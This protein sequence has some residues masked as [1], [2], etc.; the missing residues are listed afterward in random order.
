MN[1]YLEMEL[2]HGTI[3]LDILKEGFLLTFIFEDDFANIDETLQEIKG[4]IFRMP[5]EP[6]EWVQ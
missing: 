4:V 1:W 6:M 3:E 5:Q 2:Y